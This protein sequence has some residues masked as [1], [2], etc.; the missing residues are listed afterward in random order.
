MKIDL[1]LVKR[2][3]TGDKYAFEQIYAQI[4]TDLYRM[5]LYI[6]GDSEAAKD[7]VSETVLDAYKGIGK[8]KDET[9]FESWIVTI[10]SRKCKRM[11]KRKF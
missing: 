8:L 4:Y 3:G 6:L 5:A 11:I 2:A 7:A 1:E 9:S 10:L